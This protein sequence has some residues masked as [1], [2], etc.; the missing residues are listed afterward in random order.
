MSWIRA[1]ARH[2]ADY[3]GG[4]RYCFG[5]G[6]CF[7]IARLLTELELHCFNS[8]LKLDREFLALSEGLAELANLLLDFL[9]LSGKIFF[10][11]VW[12]HD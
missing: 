4:G 2:F 12:F 10:E 1:L 3:F 7:A 5:Y 8:S 6:F 9:E 11:F